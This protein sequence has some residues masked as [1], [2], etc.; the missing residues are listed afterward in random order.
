MAKNDVKVRLSAEGVSEVVAAFRKVEAEAQK[1]QKGTSRVFTDLKT[2]VAGLTGLLPKIGA[3]AAVGGL[4]AMAKAGLDAADAAGKLSQKIG[5]STEGITALQFAAST[6]DVSNEQLEKGLV[7]L[8]R[9]LQE[10]RDGTDKQVEAFGRLGLSAKDFAGQDTVQSFDLIARKLATVK[11]SGEKTAL[12]MEVFGKSGAQLI[13]LL[14]DVGREGFDNLRAKAEEL[15]LV[16]DRDT[17]AAAQAANDSFTV[18]GQQAKGLAV[19]F[20]AG[21]APTIAQAMTTFTNET[22]GKGT[23]SIKEFGAQTAKVIV[24]IINI[25]RLLGNTVGNI[26]GG[27][28]RQIGAFAAAATQLFSGNFREAVRIWQAAGEDGRRD[29]AQFQTQF[30]SDL[31]RLVDD[32]NREAP[33]FEL[34]TTVDERA[35]AD[36]ETAKER[37]D[38]DRAARE[39]K[40]AEEAARRKAEAELKEAQRV[41]DQRE[42]FEV[43]LL[44]LQGKRQ[45]AALRGLDEEL[46]KY[47]EV[48]KA[49][50][51]AE[52]ERTRILG[53]YRTAAM[54]QL[55]AQAK[56]EE[57]QRVM[58]ELARERQRIENEVALGKVGEAEAVQQLTALEQTRLA[59]L[60]QIAAAALAAA[61]AT[62]DPEVIANAQAMVQ[63][64]QNLQVEIAKTPESF[65]LLEDAAKSAADAGLSTLFDK[66]IEGAGTFRDV[67]SAAVN[68]VRQTLQQLIIEAI[69]AQ[70]L[71][72]ILNMGQG[73]SSGGVVQA[74]TGGYI[75]G[76]G[77]GTSDSIPAMLSDGEFVV[78]AS[79]VRQPGVLEALTQLNRSMPSV[80]RSGPRFAAG[81]LVAAASVPAEQPRQEKPVRIVNVLDPDLVNEALGSS[82]GEATM[83]NV[84][85]RNK[86]GIKRILR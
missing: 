63:E 3:A 6:A 31:K 65:K 66:A 51:V 12:A 80:R 44:E 76:P 33:K 55:E 40:S 72:T 42:Q 73:F 71:K 37:S 86:S 53:E 43:K 57:G 25:F 41:Q 58:D 70:I 54:A 81:G 74:A 39:A 45:E 24:T 5:A 28:G 16:I 23:K 64:V 34:Q 27:I 59:L 2:Q 29:F 56:L 50:G 18:I 69:K 22:K 13:P 82:S 10:L 36:V 1:A 61:Q 15:G 26:L 9:N 32:A 17:A 68:A 11:D 20:A 75:S 52:A 78:R 60:Q 84:I 62:K 19:Q 7:L 48:L 21:F 46:K 8:A 35:L 38:K 83:M 14:N 77:T 30:K 67:A 85:Q 79:V 49:Q 4:V 47:E